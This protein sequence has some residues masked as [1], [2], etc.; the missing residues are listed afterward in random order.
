MPGPPFWLYYARVDN[1]HE[2]A[3]K[4]KALGGQVNGPMEVPDG[5]YVVQCMDPQGAAFA[6]HS[7]KKE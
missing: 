2:S 7:T 3:E 4:V 6:L 5:D 1:P